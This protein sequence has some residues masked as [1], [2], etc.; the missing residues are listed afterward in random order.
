M[1][2]STD[3]D[4]S[5]DTNQTEMDR[6][7]PLNKNCGLKAFGGGASFFSSFFKECPQKVSTKN[8]NKKRKGSGTGTEGERKVSSRGGAGKR[9]G[10][11][12]TPPLCTVGC[13]CWL[14]PRFINNALWGQ[15]KSLTVMFVHFWAKIAKSE[16]N[17][18]SK[19]FRMESFYNQPIGLVTFINGSIKTFFNAKSVTHRT[20]AGHCDLETELAQWADS[21][22]SIWNT[23]ILSMCANS[24]WIPVT[25]HLSYVTCHLSPV[26]CHLLPV[27]CHLSPV[28][29][30]LLPVI[31]QLSPA[32]CHLSPDF[33]FMH[34]HY[35]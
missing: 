34:L 12:L 15:K 24:A 35:Y 17:V 23:L 28:T 21:V 16:N 4:S 5:T 8:F 10:T 13:Y 19:F 32:T 6:K 11:L 30:H 22:K 3:A 18:L 20:T 27:T 14:W 7:P 31:C 33:H 2:L 1:H 9:Q 26:T 25:C 29:S